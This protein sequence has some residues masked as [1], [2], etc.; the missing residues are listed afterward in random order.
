MKKKFTHWM[1]LGCLLACSW[2]FAQEDTPYEKKGLFQYFTE[3]TEGGAPAFISPE[4]FMAQ[5]FAATTK[6]GVEVLDAET[7]ELG[8]THYRLQQVLNQVPIAR[9]M[10]IVHVKDGKVLKVNGEWFRDLPKL[11]NKPVLAEGAALQQALTKVKAKTYIWE[12]KMAKEHVAGLRANDGVVDVTKPKGKLVYIS[13][14]NE[15][16]AHQLKLAFKFEV[17]AVDP[18]IKEDVYVD[19]GTGQVLFKESK[20]HK[21]NTPGT[22]STGYYGSRS[23]T[24]DQSGG[25]YYARQTGTRY[26]E[27]YNMNGATVPQNG[28][29]PNGSTVSS[30]SSTFSGSGNARYYIDAY[31]GAE[32]TLDFYKEKFNRNSYNNAGGKIEIFV[33][34]SGSIANN[35]AFWFG[36]F[37]YFGNSTS[38]TPFTSLDVVSHE[39]TH[40]VTGNSARLVYRGESGALN[41]SFS[42]IFG[43]YA[44]HYAGVGDKWTMGE[45]IS[46]QRSMSNPN[47]H[48][49]PDTYQ[50]TYWVNPSSGQDNGGVHTNSGVMNYWFYLTSEGGSGRNDRGNTFSVSGVGIEKAAQI[51]YRALTR[52]LTANSGYSAARTAVINAARDLYGTGSC[53]EAAATDAMYAVGVG[54]AFSGNCSGQSCDAVTGLSVS[55]VSTNAATVGWN[56]V[57][58]VSSYTLEYKEASAGNYTSLTVNGSS[59]NLTGLTP[60]T[61]YQIRVKYT[62][63]NGSEADYA[64]TSFTTQQDN[65]DCNALT[66]LSVGNIGESSAV[67]SWNAVS[68]VSSYSVE[69]K[70]SQSGSYTTVNANSNS[71]TLSGLT[72]STGYDVR[73]R[74]TCSN[75]ETAPYVSTTFTTSGGTTGCDGIPEWSASEYYYTGD[76][77]A[78]NN[79]IYEAKYFI[80]YYPPTDTRYWAKVGDCG[81]NSSCSAVTGLQATNITGTSAQISWNGVPGVSTYNFEYRVGNGNF[82]SETVTGNSEPFTG[83]TSGTS[84]TVRI[85][86][87]CSNGQTA[88]YASVTFTA[89]NGNSGGNCANVPEY[90]SGNIY[91]QG[92]RV[93]Y[94]GSLYEAQ[95]DG[96]YWEPIHGWWT[97]LGACSGGVNAFLEKNAQDVLSVYPNPATSKLTV[98]MQNPENQKSA[99]I[100]LVNTVGAILYTNQI[101]L[102]PGNNEFELNLDSVPAGIYILSINNTSKRVIV[103][104]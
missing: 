42:D 5:H 46:F 29:R 37:A 13:E 68:G 33:N 67:V 100:R 2:A 17:F 56:A 48:R 62:C 27:L 9:S 69:Y 53:E 34:G 41:E 73:V 10:M 74:Y 40:G 93:V 85:N 94:Q 96:I 23:I 97:N 14:G 101:S 21:A 57:S 20:I 63:T 59:R 4:A 83:L 45:Y 26:I 103:R 31:W 87:T 89:G 19:A 72:A 15:P 75:G 44:E 61:T 52:Y 104:D 51:A 12:T 60:G 7:D 95:I 54:S 43:S 47:A 82:V 25:Y 32:V 22:A 11:N 8:V 36:S 76:R 81:G 35:N 70:V 102:N 24:V 28:S 39:I 65:Q 71:V 92:D 30:T 90:V 3:Y 58:G 84:Y 86:Y 98:R 64:T 49:Q 88:D 91:Q 6:Y 18:F 50:G 38:G 1:I 78:Y 80:F 79:S 99:Y 55:Q 66:G 16:N 77:V